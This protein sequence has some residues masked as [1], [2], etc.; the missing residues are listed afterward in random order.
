[1]PDLGIYLKSEVL[2]K[3]NKVI[4]WYQTPNCLGNESESTILIFLNDRS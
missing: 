3:F 1:M 2:K 4:E